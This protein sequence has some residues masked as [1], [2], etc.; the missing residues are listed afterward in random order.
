MSLKEDA[1]NALLAETELDKKQNQLREK[2]IDL[3]FN[4]VS[5]QHEQMMQ[6]AV[7]LD[8]MKGLNIGKYTAEQTSDLVKKNDEYIEAAKRKVRFIT[9]EFDDVVPFFKKNLILVGASTGSGKSTLVSNVARNVIAQKRE[10]GTQRRVLIITN[11]EAAED[12]YNRITALI[13]GWHYNNHDKITPEQQA[14]YSKYIKLLSSSGLVTVVDNTYGGI[15]GL[16]TTI[17]G[18]TGLFDNIIENNHDYDVILIDYYQNVKSS[19]KDPT[20]EEWKVQGMFA[21]LLDKYKNILPCPIVLLAQVNRET[22]K[23][24]APFELR[25]KGRKMITDP[26]TLI[27]EIK[28][29]AEYS[30]TKWIVHK[31]RFT[32]AIGAEF[33]TGY[34]KGA[35]VEYTDQFMEAAASRR[36]QFMNRTMTEFTGK[37]KK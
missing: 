4:R 20:L 24:K 6:N 27:M 35:Y 37:E 31:S 19:K 36:E 30:R 33:F 26:C 34:D 1:L 28:R 18:V 13:K 9:K 3:D 12:C 32:N 22:E 16:T 11:E 14:E 10:D 15:N 8:N 25:I 29:E 23:D 21:H 5:L 17:E 2:K 7:D